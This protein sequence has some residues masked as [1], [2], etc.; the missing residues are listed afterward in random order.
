MARYRNRSSSSQLLDHSLFIIIVPILALLLIFIAIPNFLS[1]TSHILRPNN[2]KKSWDSLNVLLVLFAIFCGI[3]AKRY[4]ENHTN[5][6][7]EE[8]QLVSSDR[9]LSTKQIT[10][11]WFEFPDRP[12]V[13][14][15]IRRFTRNSSSYPDPRSESFCEDRDQRLRFFDDS[16]VNSYRPTERVRESVESDIKE[17]PVDTFVE[18]TKELPPETVVKF[19]PP[20]PAPPPPPPPPPPAM[21]TTDKMRRTFKTISRKEK[22]EKQ[23]N[24][25]DSNER[26]NP[27][28]PPP[29]PPPPPTA[30]KKPPSEQRAKLERKLSGTTKEIASAFAAFVNQRKKKKRQKRKNAQ[31]QSDESAKSS[32]DFSSLNLRPPPSPPPPPPPLPP[33]PSVFYNLFRKSS[34]SKQ[35]HSVAPPA[36]PTRRTPSPPPQ[37]Q[38]AVKS[39]RKPPLPAKARNYYEREEIL[40]SGGQ[41]PLIPVPAPFK[42]PE[43]KFAVRGDFDKIRST[44]SSRCGSPEL[45]DVDQSSTKGMDSG[46]LIGSVFC[47][48]PDV[49]TKADT[50]IARLRDGWR[51]EKMNSY[52]EKHG[53]GLSLAGLAQP[54]QRPSGAKGFN[55]SF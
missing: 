20:S 43:L 38:A 4:D 11:Q 49:N 28:A 37:P 23:S 29:P 31:Y 36:P 24:S 47:P 22:F 33:P 53:S 14:S 5:F 19:P 35:V 10:Q 18:K 46:D 26:R 39:R 30:G 8:E 55:L 48:S 25:V 34:K 27:P 12:V 42:P 40:N 21:V 6:Q 15:G 54:H 3:F 44:Q 41:S 16:G 1:L 2:V 9:N 50:F 13:D 51:L 7:T 52:K 45:D 17:I 32:P